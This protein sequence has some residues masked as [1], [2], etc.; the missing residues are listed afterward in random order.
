MRTSGKTTA[1]PSVFVYRSKQVVMD[2]DYNI[3]DSEKIKSEVQKRPAL[4]D[5]ATPVYSDKHCKQK[6]WTEVWV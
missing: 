5:K 6:L 1:R 2:L 4:Y 3:F